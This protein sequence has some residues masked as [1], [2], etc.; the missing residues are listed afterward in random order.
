MK[1]TASIFRAVDSEWSNGNLEMAPS[2]PLPSEPAAATDD[3]V[4]AVA[5]MAKVPSGAD[6]LQHRTFVLQTDSH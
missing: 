3:F 4:R 6:K 1:K 5:E 2:L